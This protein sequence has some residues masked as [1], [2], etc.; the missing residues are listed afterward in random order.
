MLRF[1]QDADTGNGQ[2][3][4]LTNFTTFDLRIHAL[5]G[6]GGGVAFF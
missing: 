5:H 3:L 2:I 6:L 1:N 4:A